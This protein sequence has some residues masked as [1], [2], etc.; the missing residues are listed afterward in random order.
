[1]VV[2]P[3]TPVSSTNKTDHNDIA[4]ILLEMALNTMAITLTFIN[5]WSNLGRCNEWACDKII[6]IYAVYS[7]NYFYA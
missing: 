1:L 4:E 7:N 5:F 2:S 3:G 6:N